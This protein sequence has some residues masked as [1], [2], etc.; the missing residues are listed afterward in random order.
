MWKV[1]LS[2]FLVFCFISFFVFIIC[3]QTDFD[4]RLY[5]CNGAFNFINRDVF[6]RITRKLVF[7]IY[8]YGHA[9]MVAILIIAFI[10]KSR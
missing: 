1:I 5:L 10:Q 8:A 3:S 2:C 7:P 9:V 4:V 6:E